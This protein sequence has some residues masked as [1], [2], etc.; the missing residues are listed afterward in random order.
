M[1]H[2]SIRMRSTLLTVLV[3][4]AA[5]GRPAPLPPKPAKKPAPQV[6]PIDP[7]PPAPSASEASAYLS[8]IPL[9]GCTRETRGAVGAAVTHLAKQIGSGDRAPSVDLAV[10]QR[11]LEAIW[12][13]PCLAH[14]H[15][16]VDLPSPSTAADF[17]EAWRNGLG[18]SLNASTGGF[19]L[20]DGKRKFV[21]PPSSPR[22]TPDEARRA[23]DRWLCPEADQ[24]CGHAASFVA[25]AE[26]AFDVEEESALL[27]WKD[28]PDPCAPSSYSG[29]I[30]PDKT[31]FEE[32]VRC[33]LAY[34]ARTFRYPRLR[35]RAPERGWLVLRGRRGHYAFTDEV[36]AY[37]L[38]TGAAYVARS[39]SELVLTGP[40]VDF[41]A[42]DAK[43]NLEAFTGN[44]SATLVRELAFIL[45]TKGAPRPMRSKPQ[46]FILPDDLA[47]SLTPEKPGFTFPPLDTKWADSSQTTISF[48]LIDRGALIA[49]GSFTWPGSWEPSE[50]Y[51]D[52]LVVDLEA[53]LERGCAR[54]KLPVLLGKAVSTGTSGIDADPARQVGVSGALHRALEDL[55]EPRGIWGSRPNHPQSCAFGARLICAKRK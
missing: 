32:W 54:A 39:G 31:P 5:C 36:R 40:A 51:A 42:V 47:F 50:D 10:L 13:S 29:R 34:A 11:E 49:D 3:F 30:E 20:K 46:A 23:L 19:Y 9:P 16:F 15:R 6:D 53:G 55:R 43:R 17:L 25:R 48:S 4:V 2:R 12:W 21:L 1:V 28:R 7:S 8:E 37:D 14:V 22:P 27:S 38:E 44:V 24:Q 45:V 52:K 33:T 18:P 35:F 41:A 26:R